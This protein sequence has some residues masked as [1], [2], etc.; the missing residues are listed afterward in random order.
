M[1]V[2]PVQPRSSVIPPTSGRKDLVFQP[3]NFQARGSAPYRKVA[4]PPPSA[5]KSVSSGPRLLTGSID[6]FASAT[7]VAKGMSPRLKGRLLGAGVLAAG[8][9]GLTYLATRKRNENEAAAKPAAASPEVTI[10]GRNAPPGAGNGPDAQL[11]PPAGGGSGK[12]PS[13]GP[14]PSQPSLTDRVRGNNKANRNPE[15]YLGEAFDATVKRGREVGRKHLQGMIVRD[16]VDSDTA[17]KLM[18]RYDKEIN[19]QATLKDYKSKGVTQEFDRE[20]PGKAGRLLSE[21]RSMGR[22][23]NAAPKGATLAELKARALR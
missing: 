12:G 10:A 7:K 9:A 3:E 20:N 21:Y 6:D 2:T 4:P 5:A 14:T 15:E 17:S 11:Y 16:A 23:G 18:S 19:Q 22:D 8:A 13:A 1:P